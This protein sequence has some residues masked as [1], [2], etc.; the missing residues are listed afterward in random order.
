VGA[1]PTKGAKRSVLQEGAWADMRLVDEDPT[2]ESLGKSKL[3]S[4]D[5]AP[6]L[7]PT[8]RHRKPSPSRAPVREAREATRLGVTFISQAG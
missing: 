4:T 2:Q 5:G 1:I 3:F 6:T 7:S 8:P